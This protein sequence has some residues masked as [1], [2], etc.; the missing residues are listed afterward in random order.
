[1]HRNAWKRICAQRLKDK[2]HMETGEAAATAEAL[3]WLEEKVSG[4]DPDQWDEPTHAADLHIAS[5][6][7]NR[8]ALYPAPQSPEAYH[9][10]LST[11]LSYGR[12][13]ARMISSDEE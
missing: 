5:L 4:D 7:L 13:P 12:D 1:M 9:H 8:D 3:A 10:A 6:E 2:I 11:R